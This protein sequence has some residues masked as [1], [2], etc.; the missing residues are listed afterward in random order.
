MPPTIQIVHGYTLIACVPC[1]VS[2]AYLLL[3]LILLVLLLLLELLLLILIHALTET[4]ADARHALCLNYVLD[5]AERVGVRVCLGEVF[6]LVLL[7]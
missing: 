5:L 2:L 1:P 6:A 4:A 3:L 7:L